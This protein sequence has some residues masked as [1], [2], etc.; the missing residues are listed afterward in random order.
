MFPAYG[1][2][3][4]E[5]NYVG[6]IFTTYFEIGTERCRQEDDKPSNDSEQ[7]MG[8]EWKVAFP[9]ISRIIMNLIYYVQEAKN[10][11]HPKKIL[12]LTENRTRHFRN[13]NP[14]QD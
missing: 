7:H 10:I 4:N 12:G 13:G 8:Y 14:K 1:K 6:N 2:I 3:G 11:S 5:T 9:L